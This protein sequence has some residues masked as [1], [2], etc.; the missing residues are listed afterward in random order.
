MQQRTAK[1]AQ[2]YADRQIA[3]GE[4]FAVEPKDVHLLLVLGRIEPERG[5]PGYVGQPDGYATRQMVAGRGRRARGLVA[6]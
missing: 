5:E 6:A 1:I 3:P 4:T 2:I